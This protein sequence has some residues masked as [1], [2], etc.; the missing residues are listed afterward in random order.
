ML[1]APWASSGGET[2]VVM[3]HHGVPTA[4]GRAENTEKRKG[5]ETVVA[6]E[7]TGSDRGS[8]LLPCTLN[9][10]DIYSQPFVDQFLNVHVL[11]VC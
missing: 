4:D 6:I 3:L 1:E 8:S 7:E 11:F 10:L 5:R 9:Q 2:D